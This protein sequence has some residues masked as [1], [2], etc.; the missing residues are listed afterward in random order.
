M[1]YCS[2]GHSGILHGDRVMEFPGGRGTPGTTSSLPVSGKTA[3]R[4]TLASFRI[5]HISI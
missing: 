2:K 4:A 5:P 3:L 1:Q